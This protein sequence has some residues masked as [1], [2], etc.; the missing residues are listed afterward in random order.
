MRSENQSIEDRES[1]IAILHHLSSI[2]KLL[3]A[4]ILLTSSLLTSSLFSAQQ[5]D[6]EDQARQIAA[7][8][9]CPVCQNLS[10]GDSPSE[11]AQQ[12]RALILQQLK[13]GKSRDQIKAYFVSKYGDWVLLAPPAKGFGLLVWVLPY[14]VAAAGIVLV[15]LAVRRWA[16]RKE[17]REPVAVEPSLIAQV[18]R[19]SVIEA[20]PPTELESGSPRA[21]LLQEQ[22]RLYADMRE[23][24]FDYRAGK[25]SETDYQD[26]R[27]ALETEAAVVLKKLELSPARH[28]AAPKASETRSA[29]GKQT[30][31]TEKASRP[32]WRLVAGGAF[33]LLFGI[34][35]GVLLTKSV[36]P[37]GSEQDSM[38]G[39]FLTGTGPGGIGSSSGMAGMEMKGPLSKDLPA[40]LT[41]GRAA[42]EKQEWPKAIDAFKNALALDPNQPEAHTYMGLILA[43]A[44]H[45]DGALMAF[46]RALSADPKFPLA[47]WGKGMLLYRAKEDLSGA[48]DTLQRLLQS[49]PPGAEKDQLQKTIAEISERASR[50]KGDSK[51]AATGASPPLSQGIRGT[52]TVDPKLKSKIDGQLVLFIIAYSAGSTAGP[53]LAVKKI[54]HPVF[55]LT[56]ALGPESV[57]MPGLSLSGKVRV[58]VRLDKDGNPMTKEAGNLAG[59]FKKN[60][61]AIGSQNVDIVIDRVL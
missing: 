9:R 43:Q 15:L 23:L 31:A 11:L 4:F 10:A 29:A 41:Q 32:G 12:M 21:E 56:Y 38:T 42:Y 20:S 28:A 54:E 6:L 22:A 5:A 34:T 57:M 40:L 52:I 19:E 39:D 30:V 51:K 46:D 45:A 61:V 55:P 25:L 35:V 58:T 37:R 47:L 60:P 8:L 24:D 50:Q 16:G 7:E 49:M 13:E 53:P 44:G 14:V 2:L 26:L 3:S 18:K 17:R 48:R 27:N 1:R 59:E 36:R 33:L